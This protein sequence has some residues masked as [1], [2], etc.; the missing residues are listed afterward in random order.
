MKRAFI[1]IL[2]AV[3]SLAQATAKEHDHPVSGVVFD[4]FSE[5]GLPALITLMTA[6][7]VVIDTMTAVPSDY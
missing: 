2:L 1:T 6:D 7:S 5:D 4:S 3:L